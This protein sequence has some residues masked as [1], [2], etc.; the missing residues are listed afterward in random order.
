MDQMSTLTGTPPVNPAGQADWR[1]GDQAGWT[2]WGQAPRKQRRTERRTALL[3][4]AVLAVGFTIVGVGAFL[5]FFA[6]SAGAAG[7]CGGG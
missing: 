4:T 5:Y 3:V 6:G 1:A 2:T 7:G